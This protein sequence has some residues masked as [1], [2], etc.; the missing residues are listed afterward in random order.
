[1]LRRATSCSSLSKGFSP[2]P[3]RLWNGPLR[4]ICKAWQGWHPLLSARQTDNHA[5]SKRAAGREGGRAQGGRKQHQLAKPDQRQDICLGASVT[6][7]TVT[8]PSP[9]PG[10]L[11]VPCNADVLAYE[12]KNLQFLTWGIE[13]PYFQRHQNKSQFIAH[14]LH[15]FGGSSALALHTEMQDEL[16]APACLPATPSWK[17]GQ[18]L[19][20]H[21]PLQFLKEERKVVISI[22]VIK[23]TFTMLASWYSLMNFFFLTVVG[24]FN[25]SG[26]LKTDLFIGA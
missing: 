11:V 10:L 22:H 6:A 17:L 24:I 20:Q 7:L 3:A 16:A 12:N 15:S 4:R 23:N 5:E 1:M 9:H 13:S 18:A 14:S 26:I 2:E 21:R 8:T 25:T 19:E